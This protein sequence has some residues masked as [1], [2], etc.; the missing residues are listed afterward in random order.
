MNKEINHFTEKYEKFEYSF[1]EN[2][3]FL[4]DKNLVTCVSSMLTY[5]W[6]IYLTKNHRGWELPW[7][8]IEKGENFDSALDR[9]MAEEI[10]TKVKN[11]KLFWYKKYKNYNKIKNRDWG[12]Y[13]F[14]YSYILFYIWEATGKECKIDCPDTLD[15]WLFTLKEALGKVESE[16]TRRIIEIISKNI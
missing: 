6:K 12:F 8:H 15:Y 7:G 13:P 3:E 5:K 14:P 2:P 4:E 16:W 10:W 1:I 9:E 11:K